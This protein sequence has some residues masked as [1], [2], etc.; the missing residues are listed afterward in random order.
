MQGLE[1]LKVQTYMNMSDM[2]LS[3]FTQ[4]ILSSNLLNR[5]QNLYLSVY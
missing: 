5:G 2:F 1:S 3:P 4:E